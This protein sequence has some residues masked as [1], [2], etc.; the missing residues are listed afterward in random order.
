[1]TLA[2]DPSTPAQ[3]GTTSN[4]SSIT[5]AS[6]TPPFNSGIL[7]VGMNDV[8][9]SDAISVSDSF[10]L[11]WSTLVPS[12]FL[13]NQATLAA[14]WANCPTSQA[15]TTKVS[16]ATI[17]SGVIFTVVFTGA[18]TIQNG[19]TGTHTS[20]GVAGTITLTG[21]APGS[22]VI[23]GFAIHSST[24]PTI[25]GGQTNVFNG[26]TFSFDETSEGSTFALITTTTATTGGSVTINDTAP[27]VSNTGIIAVEIRVPS[28][29][30]PSQMLG[31]ITGIKM[32][33]QR[34]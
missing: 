5:S 7:V 15:M 27:A 1:M 30:L 24:A 32:Q 33:S 10:G 12:I 34:R 28:A 26:N 22:F 11:T 18:A 17:S 14:F 2:I 29:I 31:M 20:A 23:G 3:T 9:T 16:F 21:T 13:G 6:F 8:A 4:V 19:V 25:P